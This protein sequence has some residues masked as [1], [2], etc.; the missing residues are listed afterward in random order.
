MIKDTF[1]Q[2]YKNERNGGALKTLRRTELRL[3]KHC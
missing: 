2:N 1:E 3:Y